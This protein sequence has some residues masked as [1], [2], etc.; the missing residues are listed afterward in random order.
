KEEKCR[1]PLFPLTGPK[2]RSQDEGGGRDR[3]RGDPNRLRKS[4]IANR[5]RFYQ[6]LFGSKTVSC[7]PPRH[8]GVGFGKSGSPCARIGFWRLSTLEEHR[9]VPIKSPPARNLPCCQMLCLN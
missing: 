7:N 1:W 5:R 9:V 3:A 8:I 4:C 2:R 6:S